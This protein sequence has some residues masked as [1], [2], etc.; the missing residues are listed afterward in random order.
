MVQ[1]QKLHRGLLGMRKRTG[2]VGE[3]LTQRRKDLALPYRMR[4]SHLKREVSWDC[5][6]T[7]LA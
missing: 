6:R 4:C 3:G 2:H 1:M 5:D 7:T